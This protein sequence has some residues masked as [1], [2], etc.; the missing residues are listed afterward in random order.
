MLALCIYHIPFLVYL[1]EMP[2]INEVDTW[3][4]GVCWI[5]R[6]PVVFDL[7]VPPLRSPRPKLSLIPR[8]TGG[9]VKVLTCNQV[10]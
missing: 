8:S 6:I 1:S 5:D 2:N 10:I 3:S 4:E 7:L 9:V